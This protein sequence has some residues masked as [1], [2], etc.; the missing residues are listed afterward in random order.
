MNGHSEA[1][2]TLRLWRLGRRLLLGAIILEPHQLPL[3]CAILAI[4]DQRWRF[5]FGQVVK[6][7]FNH[8]CR[9]VTN[10]KGH[11]LSLLIDRTADGVCLLVGT[12]VRVATNDPLFV[13]GQLDRHR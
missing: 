10:G 13:D 11:A 2:R 9:C 3:F 5:V 4:V 8:G 12:V 7:R 1:C 6:A